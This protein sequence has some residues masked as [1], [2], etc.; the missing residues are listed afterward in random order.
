[1]PADGEAR[2]VGFVGLGRLGLPL[3]QRLLDAG[4]AVRCC[5]R[6]RSD[7]LV[8]KGATIAGDGSPRAVAAACDVV[9]TCLPGDRLAAVFEGEDGILAAG[10]PLPLV[11]ELSVAPVAEK[12]RFRASLAAGGGDLLDCPVSGTPAMAAA[13]VAVIYAS[14][15]RSRHGRVEALLQALSPAA[16]YVGPLGDGMR[17]KYVANLLVLV[18]VA[19]AAEAMA[20]ARRLGLDLDA[21]V[22]LISRSPAAVSGQFQVRAPMIVARDFDGRLVD[23]RDAR[24]VLEQ[25]TAAA[26]GAGAAVPL[27]TV[28]KALFDDLGDRGDD[29]SDPAKLA[30]ALERGGTPEG[31]LASDPAA[32]DDPGA[33]AEIARRAS[34]FKHL[35]LYHVLS[36]VDATS[37]APTP[38]VILDHQA[39][40]E[41]LDRSGALFAAGPIVDEDGTVAGDG[42]YLVRA[43]SVE[44]AATLVADDPF[45]AGGYRRCTIR[46]WS[47]HQGT[48]EEVAR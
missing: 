17:M 38:Q 27:A 26:R 5:R 44:D 19:A 41:A 40:A 22:E 25:V 11:V 46:P 12:E 30:V 4:H 9:F 36:K 42:V 13:G 2:A 10:R 16:T 3:A 34:A 18:H 48:F 8:A 32:V 7:E 1:M 43:A 21:V 14:G 45:H 20:L 15:D 23:V 37:P 6:G 24:E 31:W 29:G 33:H 47:V 35:R 39:W 28:A